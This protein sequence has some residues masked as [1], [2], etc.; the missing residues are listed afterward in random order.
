MAEQL[1]QKYYT[2]IFARADTQGT[3]RIDGRQA[4]ALFRTSGVE[5]QTLRQI[6]SLATPSQEDHL[7]KNRFFV[8]LKLIALAQSGHS[9]SIQL[10][11]EK[12]SLPKFE[13]IELPRIA[14][15]WEVGESELGVYINGFNKLSGDK[16][17]LTGSE[18]KELL[19]RTQFTPLL[20]KKIWTLVGMN[21]SEN[22]SQDQFIV[23]MQLIAKIRAGVEAPDTLPLSLD[24]IINKPK[25]QVI[26]PVKEERKGIEVPR[27][28]DPE[29]HTDLPRPQSKSTFGVNCDENPKLLTSRSQVIE[30]EKHIKDQERGLKEKNNVLK[31]IVEL[32]E[33]DGAELEIMKEKNMILSQKLKE[34]EDIFQK[35]QHKVNKAKDKVI[36]ELTQSNKIS[37]KLKKENRVLQEKI[38]LMKN[39]PQQ[40][41]PEESAENKPMPK[42]DTGFGTNNSFK[43]KQ[44]AGYKKETIFATATTESAINFPLSNKSECTENG[45]KT[46]PITDT[47][48]ERKVIEDK[49]P[50][51]AKPGFLSQPNANFMEGVS[52]PKLLKTEFKFEDKSSSSKKENIPQVKMELKASKFDDDIF[53]GLDQPK[54]EVKQPVPT[55][56][57]DLN[58]SSSSDDPSDIAQPNPNFGFKFSGEIEKKIEKRAFKSNSNDFDKKLNSVEPK[59]NTFDPQPN[60]VEV[61]SNTFDFKPDNFEFKPEN[62]AFPAQFDGFNSG[63]SFPSSSPSFDSD[64][65][66]MDTQAIKTKGN[67]RELEF[68]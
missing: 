30:Y 61:K 19:L 60:S 15:G 26:S 21:S 43:D 32:L 22:M 67:T 7:D 11:H 16:G 25:P 34:S 2:S 52:V 18:S 6:W 46:E 20:L 38:D 10:L 47:K 24:R 28:K 23:A 48:E 9:V 5:V 17:Y 53:A 41:F 40:K 51:L 66:K 64:F 33:I 4:V 29:A 44:N 65:F 56:Y 62:I 54:L 8:A 50:F 1:E 49:A 36:K 13:G 57:P 59:P 37:K 35:A 39:N 42:A 45:Y 14:D 3:G 27:L 12:T 63:F 68:D 31:T 55:K 58:S